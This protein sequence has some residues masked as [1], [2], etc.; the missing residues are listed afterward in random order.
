MRPVI[1]LRY[2]RITD[3]YCSSISPN[4]PAKSDL[5]G[6]TLILIVAPVAADLSLVVGEI[7]IE[8]PGKFGPGGAYAQ[9]YALF[10][11]SMAAATIFGPVFSGAIITQ[12]GWKSMTIAVGIF[13]ITGAI[14]C[15]STGRIAL[16]YFLG[17]LLSLC[18][19]Q[20]NFTDNM[21]VVLHWGQTISK[22]V[23]KCN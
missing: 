17:C 10:N 9:A 4:S 7:E 18:R 21:T 2:G 8:N 3:P 16:F 14:P 13:S 20:G 1:Y 12:Y 23:R 6:C 5:L 15:V 22:R 11:C 19:L